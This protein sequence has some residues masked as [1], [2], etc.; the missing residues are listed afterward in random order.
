MAMITIKRPQYTAVFDEGSC[1][2]EGLYDAV[3]PAAN[4]IGE[5]PGMTAGLPFIMGTQW[6]DHPVPLTLKV[7]DD[8]NFE[9]VSRGGRAKLKYSFPEDRIDLRLDLPVGC[10][11]RSGINL[12]FNLLDTPCEHGWKTQCMPKVIY[13]GENRDYGYFVF[14]TPDHRYMGLAVNKPFACWRIKYS[15][16]GHRMTGFQLLNEADDVLTEG[17]PPLKAVS[18]LEGSIVFAS[19]AGE[20]LEKISRILDLCIVDFPVSGGPAGS[21]I[22]LKLIGKGSIEITAPD[23]SGAEA[24]GMKLRLDQKG[25]YRLTGVSPSGRKHESGIF[26][27]SSW[28]EIYDKVN[29]FYRD[30]FQDEAGAFYRVIRAD[31]LRPDGCRT[32][33][34]ISF[35][36]VTEPMSCRTGEFGGFA[37]W[38]MIKNC[39]TFGEKPEFMPAIE[40]YLFNWAL[41]KAHEDKPYPGTINSSA[42]EYL[43]RVYGPMHLYREINYPQHEEFLMEEMADYFALTKNIE[44]AE[45]AF[46][47]GR[48]FV[49]EHMDGSGMVICQNSKDGHVVDYSTV[50]TPIAALIRLADM[51]MPQN[52]PDER[53]F[54]M[55]HAEK[56]ADFLCRRGF[57]FPTEGEQMTEDGSMS[58]T[59]ISLLWAYLRI[60]PKTEYLTLAEEILSCHRVL[61]LEGTD[62]RIR[63]SSLRFWETQYETRDWGPS[64]NAGHAW[65]IWTA[66]AK[67]LMALIKKDFNLLREAWEGFVA[68]ICKVRETGAMPSCYTPDMIPGTP[69]RPMHYA[70]DEITELLPTSSVLAGGYVRGTYACSGNYFLVKAAE[71]WGHISAYRNEDGVCLNGLVKGGIFYSHAPRFDTLLLTDLPRGGFVFEAKHH[72]AVAVDAA[73]PVSGW[74]TKG[75]KIILKDDRRLV[76]E[77]TAG[78]VVL[79]P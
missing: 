32:F 1:R 5:G 25:R 23:G 79:K 15:Y 50:H 73:V 6:E 68:N 29:T 37:A 51:S 8:A 61:E 30:H 41:N 59:V 69:H 66:E 72:G 57:S 58:C 22:P 18:C 63:G 40:K 19:G 78:Q 53:A 17:G 34:G 27:Q 48:H 2:L 49:S 60:K 31:T 64:I 9:A 47:L 67:A 24:G 62:C 42:S 46:K 56:I 55:E 4:W 35:G 14:S 33:E 26:C 7:C 38:A 3:C 13:T 16:A 76:L 36:D 74:Q 43:G 39:L 20:C 75:A 70:E 21:E 11:P 12:D 10:G 54:F 28:E 71:I 44:I 52:R 65:T 77:P 45:K